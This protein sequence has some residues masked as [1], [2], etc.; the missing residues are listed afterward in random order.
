MG[1]W[2]VEFEGEAGDRADCPCSNSSVAPPILCRMK[3]GHSPQMLCHGLGQEDC[4]ASPV[5][6]W[7]GKDGHWEDGGKT[8]VPHLTRPAPAQEAV[9]EGWKEYALHLEKKRADHD[10]GGCL[11]QK[12]GCRYKIDLLIPDDLWELI[13]PKGKPTG[14]GLLCGSC[15]MELLEGLGTFGAMKAERI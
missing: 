15:I 1:K 9:A 5:P 11:C 12:C 6:D 2:V 13:K 8:F 10:L 14:A 4:P 3:L 7:N